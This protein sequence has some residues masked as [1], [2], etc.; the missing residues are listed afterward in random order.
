MGKHGPEMRF[1]TILWGCPT[2]GKEGETV[3]FLKHDWGIE[4]VECLEISM[5]R[6]LRTWHKAQ[7]PDCKAMIDVVT[8]LEEVLAAD[9]WMWGEEAEEVLSYL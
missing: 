6:G 1:A 7:S 9:P 4:Q 3:Q 5:M 2:C 8:D